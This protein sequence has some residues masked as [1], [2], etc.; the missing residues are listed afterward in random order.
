[1]K[2]CQITHKNTYILRYVISAP[3]AKI[4]LVFIQ[5]MFFDILSKVMTMEKRRADRINGGFEA[6]FTYEGNTY[7]GIIDNLSE[8]GLNF[9]SAPTDIE[10]DFKPGTLLNLEFQ[11]SPGEKL[12]LNCRIKWA[13][14]IPPRNLKYDI[15]ME[16]IDPAWEDSKYFL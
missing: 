16:V 6:K 3:G 4:I 2:K 1:M 8:S 13:K 12:V 10:V 15:G 14:K 9:L 5:F 11:P 7:N